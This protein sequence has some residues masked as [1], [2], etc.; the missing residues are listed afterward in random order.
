MGEGSSDPWRVWAGWDAQ[1]L[2]PFTLGYVNFLAVALIIPASL[3]TAPIGVRLAHAFSR[4]QLEL[5]FATFLF[6]VAARFLY[7][8]FT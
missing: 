7:A 8:V 2:P 1:G 5:A 6:F 3:L 4:R